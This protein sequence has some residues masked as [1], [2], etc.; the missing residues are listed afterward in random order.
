MVKV[1]I[2]YMCV[3][4]SHLNHNLKGREK[5][6][7]CRIGKPKQFQRIISVSIIHFG[8]VFGKYRYLKNHQVGDTPSN[9]GT[10]RKG[11]VGTEQCEVALTSQEHFCAVT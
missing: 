6:E 10:G 11:N 5:V 4:V 7:A 9:S 8:L 2:F 1:L 3:C